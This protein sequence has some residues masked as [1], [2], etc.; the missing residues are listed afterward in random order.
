MV[1]EVLTESLSVCRLRG[2]VPPP[3]E[4]LFFLAGTDREWSLVC[5]ASAVPADCLARE[6]GWRAFRIAGTLDFSLVGVLAGIL[7]VLETA[8][9]SVF[10][11]STYCTDYVL[12]K[13]E[14]LEAALAVLEQNGYTIS[15]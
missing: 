10:V 15:R 1:L 2:P 11:Q 13:A 4:G 12:V 5:S 14:Q 6:D 9:I 8:G 7:R 3:A